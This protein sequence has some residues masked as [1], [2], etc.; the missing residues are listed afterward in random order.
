MQ[1]SSKPT[2]S[3]RTYWT[4]PILVVAGI[5]CCGVTVYHVLN[6]S[7]FCPPSD[8]EHYVLIIQVFAHTLRAGGL[9]ACWELIQT[10]NVGWP[11]LTF[12]LVH[13]P[14][15][16]TLGESA[17]Q[18]RLNS[19]VVVPVLMLGTF[20]LGTL[21]VD[22][23]V[24]ALA[25]AT[26]V[27]TLGI[28]GGLRQVSLD[29]TGTAVATLAMVALVRAGD[30]TR[31]ARVVW[32]GALCGVCLLTRVQSTMV[33]V[34]PVLVA[35]ALALW[36]APSWRVRGRV[37][38][39]LL[40]AAAVAMAVCSPWWYGRLSWIFYFI[41]GHLDPEV[42]RPRGGQAGLINGLV[43]YLPALGRL[44]GWHL[45]AAAL[46]T[47]P[48]LVKHRSPR[49]WM[50][51]LWIA[52]AVVGCS[53]GVHRESKYLLP[54]VPAVVLLAFIGLSHLGRLRSVA[55]APWRRLSDCLPGA[56]LLLT[57]GPLLYVCAAPL[58]SSDPLVL[59]R[60]VDWP[61]VRAPVQDRALVPAKL[62]ASKLRRLGNV[63]G[64]GRAAYLVVAEEARVNFVARVAALMV[65]DFPEMALSYNAN[66]NFVNSPW[67]RAARTK[68]SVFILSENHR[69]LP[70]QHLWTLEAGFYSNPTPIRLYRVP[71][72]HPHR[73][74]MR[75]E[76][77]LSSRSKDDDWRRRSTR[78]PGAK[79][80]GTR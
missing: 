6:S 30:M 58:G 7:A 68:R 5:L 10:L 46:L 78:R 25:A 64:R 69:Q 21:L 56:M 71:H 13:G 38:L 55:R 20:H 11:P 65:N 35:S 76:L 70:F 80:K 2:P 54:A 19:L 41:G 23:R 33:L 52:G 62:A 42:I 1:V 74:F 48:L 26:T 50:L 15:A 27:L 17:Q 39:L 29:V 8:S 60:W 53:A 34:G 24:G 12:A 73:N 49:A 67:N 9:P 4:L 57:V 45:L 32:L 16:L 59:G 51:V 14:L 47:F 28:T 61:Y 37:G 79:S 22:R 36:R 66:M 3:D 44:A 18:I 31:P 43:F 77:F 75:R 40:L 63:S 72:G